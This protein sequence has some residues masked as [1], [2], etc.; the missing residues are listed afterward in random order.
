MQ[1]TF[2]L[3]CRARGLLVSSKPKPRAAGRGLAAGRAHYR[4]VSGPD[5]LHNSI[6]LGG[7]K[8]LDARHASDPGGF[9]QAL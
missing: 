1:D 8:L 4:H 7:D 3:L 5:L 6:L 2:A 9:L